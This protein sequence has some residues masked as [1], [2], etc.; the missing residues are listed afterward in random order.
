M[1]FSRLLDL[2]V[3]TPPA[4]CDER[5]LFFESWNLA[6]VRSLGLELPGFVQENFSLSR[7][8]V[9]RGLHYQA[10]AAAQG[11]LVWAV[12]GLIYDVAVDLRRSSP[13]F[14]QW[15]A[16]YLRGPVS[17]RLYIPPGFAHG[18][19][20]LTDDCMVGYA[21]TTPYEPMAER[22]L[23][24]NDA[25]L[26]IEWPLSADVEPLVSAKDADAKSFADCDKFD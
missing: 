8:G 11:K 17:E 25:I 21:C 18:F 4:Y 26:H 20:A 19:L 23:L 1:T 9:L 5:G 2:A 24:W 15:E 22:S 7:K 12:S 16:R 10:G 6:K 13:T 3:V 14:G